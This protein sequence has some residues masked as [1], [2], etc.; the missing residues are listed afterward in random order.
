M[1]PKHKKS[2]KRKINR[3][4]ASSALEFYLNGNRKCEKAFKYRVK[5]FTGIDL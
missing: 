5:Q 4:L 3:S 2:I 1:N